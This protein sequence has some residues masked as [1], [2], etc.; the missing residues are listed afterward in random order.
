MYRCVLF[1]FVI[2][3]GVVYGCVYPSVLP[4][5]TH[6]VL[7]SIDGFDDDSVIRVQCNHSDEFWTL[8]CDH[9]NGTWK[10]QLGNCTIG[11]ANT[12]GQIYM[13]WTGSEA[14]IHGRRLQTWRRVWGRKKLSRNK[15]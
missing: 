6:L 11:N 4:P 13:Q 14:S 9:R 2:M 8:R 7:P 1:C 10:G 12:N 5:K 15:F 3:C